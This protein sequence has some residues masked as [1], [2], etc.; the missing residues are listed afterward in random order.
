MRD[1]TVENSNT[2]VVIILKQTLLQ[3]PMGLAL[4]A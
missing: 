1:E 4:L 2:A 3:R